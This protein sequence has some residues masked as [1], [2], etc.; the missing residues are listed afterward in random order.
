MKT[1][2]TIALF[3]MA[4]VGLSEL[5]AGTFV[6]EKGTFQVGAKPESEKTP[7]SIIS[8]KLFLIIS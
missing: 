3:F 4:V 6:E 7:R 8:K 5:N 1:S 2:I